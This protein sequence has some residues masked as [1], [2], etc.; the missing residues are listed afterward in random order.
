MERVQTLP[1]SVFVS[2]SYVQRADD[3]AGEDGIRCHSYVTPES[4]D[5]LC[6]VAFAYR[7][8]VALG[9]KMAVVSLQRGLD[10]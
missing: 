6:A 2:Q 10:Q 1:A 8:S 9:S 4:H 3:K 5:P 7:S